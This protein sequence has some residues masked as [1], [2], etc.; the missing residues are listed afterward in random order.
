[1]NKGIPLIVS[2]PSGCGKD[3]LLRV[4]FE[5]YPQVKFSI[6]AVTRP[7]RGSDTEDGKYRFVTR[8]QFEQMLRDDELL[9]HNEYVGNYYGTPRQPVSD[10]VNNGSD[11]VLEIDVNGAA[12]I[13]E[14]LPEAVSVFIM[15]PSM[16]SLRGR[17]TGRGTE[18]AEVVEQR[19]AQ[20]ISEIGRAGEYDYIVIN[21][22]L[23]TAADEIY[24]IL[25]AEKAK[26]KNN[27]NFINEVLN[28][29]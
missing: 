6:S 12:Q 27:K 5:K 8:E 7:K 24:S 14:K 3:T 2:G 15:P 25:T 26:Y 10:A 4:L 11:I 18:A 23:Q 22:D 1:M 9:E 17:L 13:R 21:D 20:A 28:N 19:L 29:A 16:D